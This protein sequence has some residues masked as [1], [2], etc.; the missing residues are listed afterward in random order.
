MEKLS[1]FGRIEE[2]S[3]EFGEA[4]CEIL[5]VLAAEEHGLEEIGEDEDSDFFNVSA[6]REEWQS[7]SEEFPKVRSER[8]RRTITWT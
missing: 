7:T 8:S 6:E 5:T 3:T 2:I 4:M 1:P